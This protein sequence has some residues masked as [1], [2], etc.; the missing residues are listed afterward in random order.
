MLQYVKI[1]P[2]RAILNR[3]D[4]Q[5]LSRVLNTEAVYFEIND[6]SC[7]L[8]YF[9]YNLGS[10]IESLDYVELSERGSYYEFYSE[11]RSLDYEIDGQEAFDITQ[12]FFVS[13]NIYPI[14]I[15]W[16]NGLY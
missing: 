11:I 4:A 1:A 3:E 8:I 12:D 13:S 5:A 16:P 9:Y 14:E 15:G 2:I 6:I 7:Y 10:L